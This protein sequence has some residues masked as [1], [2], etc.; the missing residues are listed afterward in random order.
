MFNKPKQENTYIARNKYINK[1]LVDN[2]N[3]L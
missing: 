2:E 1:K 3:Y